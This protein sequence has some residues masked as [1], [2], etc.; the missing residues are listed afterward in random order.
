MKRILGIFAGL[1]LFG[2]VGIFLL[3]VAGYFWIARDLPKIKTITDYSPPLT[4]T[5][6]TR[7][8]KV[9]GYLSR[10][11]R[12][13]VT[14]NQVSPYVIK[15]FLAAEDS[16]FYQHG[17]VDVLGI[18]RAAIKNLQ[19]GGIVQGGSTITQQV[20]KSL[21]LT[22]ERSYKR[23]L[24]EAILAYQ[25]EKYLTKDEILTI[26]LNQ[27]YLGE[28]AYGVEAASR[29]Y[30]A[31]HAKDL[32]LSQAALLAGL[33]KA[34]AHYDP[35]RHPDQ[36]RKRQAYV[37]H[38]LLKLHWVTREE[39][40]QALNSTLHL[41][42]MEDPSWKMG[43]YYLEAVRQWLV[44]RYGEQQTY[45]GGLKVYTGI[46]LRHQQAA[47]QALRAGLLASTKRR[48]FRGP[49]F[50]LS[51]DQ[52]ASFLLDK[53]NFV[54]P[55]QGKWVRVLV[56][57]VRPE[58]AE[59]R[60]M[61]QKGFIDVRSMAWCRKIDPSHAPEEVPKIKDAR[62]VLT[63]GDVVWAS[64]AAA[65]PDE[66]GAWAL[67]LE[68][69]PEVQ[70]ALVSLDPKSGQVL[71]MVGGYDFASSQFNRATQALRQTGSAFKPIVYS[72]ALDNGFTAA[73]VLLDAPIVFTDLE[74]NKVWKPQNYE[75]LNFGP[76]LLRTALVKSRN[77]VTI[78]LA[79]AVGIS[80]VIK[81]A[82][83]LGLKADFPD[84]LSVSLGTASVSLINLC[85]AYTGFARGGA[86][87]EPYLIDRVTDS[88]GRGLYQVMPVI[89]AALS[90]QTA[91]IINYL[92]QQVVQDGTGWRARALHRPVAGKTG[93]T[94]EQKDAWFMG[95]APYLL[96]GVYV[97]FDQPR[98][99]GKY[100]TGSRAAC[101]VWVQYRQV[102]EDFYP[103]T[104][105]A[106]PPGIVMARV[107][108]KTG[109]LAGPGSQKSYLLPFKAGTQPTEI[110]SPASGQNGEDARGGQKGELLK[111]LF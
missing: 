61:D 71:A 16:G 22:P 70:G 30:F 97:G 80:K 54:Q 49:L 51:F 103:V 24:K 35:Y 66:D 43:A 4:T 32:T 38:R 11:N 46:D 25:L 109:L 107:D 104:D 60:F 27:I 98:P 106:R 13:L 12:F 81:R 89:K 8:N 77:L 53:K 100:E 90:P 41:R 21:L 33:P 14:L 50:H 73:S 75:Q 7:N 15:A 10:E 74:T 44:S 5:V 6:F 2:L 87:V 29:V 64:F 52:F 56:V 34:P 18:I 86:T 9:L 95:Y 111:E 47:E 108:A 28:G 91:Y 3:A 99:M 37:L 17:G 83:D 82:Q 105:F 79:K 101:P 48:G 58:G 36:A 31:C 42:S 85:Q 45:G 65:K 96:T 93:T 23:K 1:F 57:E 20:I 76:T 78:R 62:Q 84:N 67:T 92:L 19:A 68:Q 63:V 39:Y 55:A 110:S 40:D 94:D 26:Y 72:A 102:V 69:Q 59:V 88:W